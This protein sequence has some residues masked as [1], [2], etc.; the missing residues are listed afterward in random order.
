MLTSV[1][2]P[3]KKKGW[4][5]KGRESFS[6]IL[7][8]V[9]HLS[10]NLVYIMYAVPFLLASRFLTQIKGFLHCAPQYV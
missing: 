1:R 2:M 6:W 10:P 4:Q 7:S 9:F 3:E 5:E 8:H